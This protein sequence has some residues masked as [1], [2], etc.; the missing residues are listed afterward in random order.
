MLGTKCHFRVAKCQGASNVWSPRNVR[1]RNVGWGEMSLPG[2][3][4]SMLDVSSLESKKMSG[5][6]NVRGRN[7]T[8]GDEMSGGE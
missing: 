7:V 4:C 5:G 3:K 8:S 2:A 6:R 1:G